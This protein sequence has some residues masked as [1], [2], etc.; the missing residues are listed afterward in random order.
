MKNCNLNI[1]KWA[2]SDIFTV[3]LDIG[4]FI[5]FFG[6]CLEKI[7]CKNITFSPFFDI[8]NT[9]FHTSSRALGKMYLSVLAEFLIVI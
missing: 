1:K 2:K 7:S 4:L 3:F 6:F 5:T 8:L 9:I